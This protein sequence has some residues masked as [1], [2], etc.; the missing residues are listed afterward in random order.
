MMFLIS[1]KFLEKHD[2]KILKVRDYII[3]DGSD[4]GEMDDDARH[5]SV[6][7]RYNFV[8]INGGFTPHNRLI[9]SMKEDLKEGIIAD[10]KY[11]WKTENMLADFFGDRTFIGSVLSAVQGFLVESTGWDVQR[12]VFIVLPNKVYR[13]MG[14]KI[15]TKFNE[16]LEVDFQFIYSEQELTD[17]KK[18]LKKD[19]KEKK[20][21]TL[22]KRI[23]KVA[24]K[25][26][27]DK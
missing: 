17:D 12:N 2:K 19:L 4:A 11:S 14:D 9:Q 15:L 1:Q 22:R 21:K 8:V 7:N 5:S 10:G 20:M 26:K 24:A 23:P 16:L 13:L 27:L 25:Y 3:V 6:A 18:L